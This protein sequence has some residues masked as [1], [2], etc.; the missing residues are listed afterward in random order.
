M[1]VKATHLDKATAVISQQL[2][3][4]RSCP[5]EVFLEKGVLKQT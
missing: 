2:I 4:G 1:L 5:P 3:N